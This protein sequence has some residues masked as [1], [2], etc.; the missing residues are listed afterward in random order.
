MWWKMCATRDCIR[1]GARGTSGMLGFDFQPSG[2]PLSLLEDDNL[3]SHAHKIFSFGSIAL[4]T[5]EIDIGFF[6]FI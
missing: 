1:Y 5:R 2:I 6:I 3:K 4:Y